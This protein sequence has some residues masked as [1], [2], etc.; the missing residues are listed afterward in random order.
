MRKQFGLFVIMLL[1]L[2]PFTIATHTPTHAVAN[3]AAYTIERVKVDGIT[4]YD[5][6]NVINTIEIER[7]RDIFV[8]VFVEGLTDNITGITETE[9]VTVEA[10]IDGYDD[11]IEAET[12][13]FDVEEDVSY[14]KVLRLTIP[15]DIDANEFY[16]LE[17]KVSDRSNSVTANIPL[18]VQEQEK[19]LVIED[20]I[21]DPGLSVEAGETLYTRVFIDYFGDEEE[22]N[23]RIV[24]KVPAL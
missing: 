8:E 7:G 11:D 1:L 9:D 21:F 6:N 14:R 10:E 22:E 4:A 20:V 2:A 3:G 17:I 24:V 19:R 23:I 13:K 15:E 5:N 16:T 12:E 18:R